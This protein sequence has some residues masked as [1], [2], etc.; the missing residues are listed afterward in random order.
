MQAVSFLF[1]FLWRENYRVPLKD[2]GKLAQSPH[3]Y[4][5]GGGGNDLLHSFYVESATGYKPKTG[6]WL[7]IM[8]AY[9]CNYDH[10]ANYF[11]L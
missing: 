5:G 7:C 4:E 9:S 11:C 6:L 1:N 2:A 3:W 10:S 8:Q